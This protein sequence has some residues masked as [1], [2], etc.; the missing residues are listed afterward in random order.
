MAAALNPAKRQEID[1]PALVREE[2]KPL[3]FADRLVDQ[4]IQMVRLMPDVEQR[5]WVEQLKA[6]KIDVNQLI[7]RFREKIHAGVKPPRIQEF[8][9]PPLEPFKWK[10]GDLFI[11]VPQL[12]EDSKLRKVL[13][14]IP[15]FGIIPTI[16]N[17]RSL[18]AKARHP[19]YKPILKDIIRVKNHYKIASII[20]TGLTLLLAIAA[21]VA[22]IAAGVLTGGLALGVGL[23]VGFG[24]SVMAARFAAS[25]AERIHR[26]QELLKKIEA[27]TLPQGKPLKLA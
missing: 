20:R 13:A 17:E 6:K 10:E 4:V 7:L 16:L 1:L 26:N 11:K 8:L 15:L 22:I 25:Y 3:H 2:L 24:A 27:N 9:L 21:V 19:D 12:P 5:E 18:K 23:G 14:C